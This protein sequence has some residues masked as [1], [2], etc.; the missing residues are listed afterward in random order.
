[1]RSAALATAAGLMGLW[2][3]AFCWKLVTAVAAEAAAPAL[4]APAGPAL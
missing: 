4:A 3:A 2:V 1:M